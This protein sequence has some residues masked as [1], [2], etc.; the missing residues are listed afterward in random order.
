[1]VYL[2]ID[3]GG[4][5]TAA[6]ILSEAGEAIGRGLGGPGSLAAQDDA[7][8]SY[9]VR[10]SVQAACREAGLD[11]KTVRF[12][13]VCAGMAGYSLTARRAA[14]A[15]LLNQLVRYDR[16]S[17]APDY[18]TAYWGATG[19]RPGIVMIAGTGAVA[20]GRNAA[21][22]TCREDGLGFLLGDRGSGFNL[23]LRALRHTLAL[24]QAGAPDPLAEAVAAH[25]TARTSSELMQWLYSGFSP[26]R[27]AGLAP[28]VGALAEAGDVSARDLVAEMARQLRHS[29]REVRHQLRMGADAPVYPLGG[30]WQIGAF[31]RAE[32]AC[33]RWN[34]GGA[35][36]A[37]ESDPGGLMPTPFILAE[38]AQDAA[39]GAALLARSPGALD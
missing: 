39:F 9:A 21:G 27:V 8:L 7:A 33:P 6:L 34:P 10:Q 5:K 11:Y 29:V 24:E 30:L 13:G 14:F 2:G 26:A 35:D 38:P 22:E 4:T 28:V 17:V 3:G 15:T 18:L 16:A 37:N 20:F 23:G 12:Q 25:T 1:M 32:F 36:G 31:L 19:G